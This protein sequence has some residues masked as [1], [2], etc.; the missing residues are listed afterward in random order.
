MS[1]DKSR[2]VRLYMEMEGRDEVCRILRK[3]KRDGY[4]AAKAVKE[5]MSA[6]R[7]K[8][9]LVPKARTK[10]ELAQ[11]KADEEQ[12]AAIRKRYQDYGHEHVVEHA[13]RVEAYM[14]Y[15]NAK[16]ARLER[17]LCDAGGEW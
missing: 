14:K 11:R 7:R 4:M 8:Q 2:V 15:G 3:C 12:L 13:Y 10:K 17:L 6:D 9:N 5:K 1:P 16:I